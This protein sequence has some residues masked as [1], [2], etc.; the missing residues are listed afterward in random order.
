M[1]RNHTTGRAS[2]LLELLDLPGSGL[3]ERVDPITG[4]TTALC[5]P[6]LQ[7]GFICQFDTG[8]SMKKRHV[9]L[10]LAVALVTMSVASRAHAARI[11]APTHHLV[12]DGIDKIYYCLGTPINC[13][14][15][16][17]E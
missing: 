12:Y 13:D 11:E 5:R 15:G 16:N 6:I 8:G 3:E 10:W 1:R 9:G 2:A 14:F 4:L 17:A 7:I